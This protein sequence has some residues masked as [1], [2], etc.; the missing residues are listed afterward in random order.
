VRARRN[1]RALSRA[2]V[3]RVP[4]LEPYAVGGAATVENIELR[5]RAHNVHEA[6]QYFG[7]GLPLL[8]RESRT[9]YAL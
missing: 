8:V 2:R 1:A 9:A 6:K 4:S 7:T 3:P 5:C